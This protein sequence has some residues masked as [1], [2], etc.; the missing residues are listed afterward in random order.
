MKELSTHILVGQSLLLREPI[1]LG[2]DLNCIHS[3]DLI[4]ELRQVLLFKDGGLDTTEKSH[5][6][7]TQEKSANLR[8]LTYTQMI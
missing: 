5:V 8:D 6:G 1:I 2:H 3:E 7:S 4:T